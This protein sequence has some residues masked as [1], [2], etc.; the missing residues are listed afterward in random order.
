MNQG[1]RK[2]KVDFCQSLSS[3]FSQAF[4]LQRTVGNQ[5]VQKLFKYGSIQAKL[6][7]SQKGNK[8]EQDALGVADQVM[9]TVEPHLQRQIESEEKEE[10]L[11]T[12]LI[13]DQITPLVQRQ[14]EPEEEE[15][16]QTKMSDNDQIQRQ[17]AEPEEEEGETLQTK[18]VKGTS[19]QSSAKLDA[20]INTVKSGGRP[21]PVSTRKF[22]EARLGSDFSQ[23]RIHDD[24]RAAN[25][26]KSLNAKAFTLGKD[27]A[28]GA[29]QYMPETK[30]GKKIIAHELTHVVQQGKKNHIKSKIQPQKE[31]YWFQDKPPKEKGEEEIVTRA[32]RQRN[33]IMESPTEIFS[34]GVG[35]VYVRFAYSETEMQ[36]GTGNSG[37]KL[38]SEIG[39]AKKIIRDSIGE[40]MQDLYAYPTPETLKEH[41]ENL[42]T[43]ARLKETLKFTKNNPFNIYLTST[44]S[45]EELTSGEAYPTTAKIY[46]NIKDVGDKSKLQPAIR[47]PVKAIV[48][49]MSAAE[50][51]VEKGPTE[52]KKE[53]KR[54]MLHENIHVM[55]LKRKFDAETIWNKLKSNLKL[56]G[57]Q[58][59]ISKIE[60]LAKFYILAQEEI[61]AY[62][63]VGKL[64]PPVQAQKNLY[65][66]FKVAAELFFK[67]DLNAKI[68]V[69][70]YKLKVSERIKLTKKSRLEK[71]TWEMLVRFPKIGTKI[72]KDIAK[73]VDSIM[74]LWPL[75]FKH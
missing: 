34:K 62:A 56:T 18:Q 58:D 38:K 41:R 64:Y 5:A 49:G 61:F 65:E 69:Q 35:T 4:S 71:V 68:H 42:S 23:V 66:M 1:F 39:D 48:K 21:L 28:F 30:E 29:G 43:R 17:E 53:L 16:I 63:E 67:N 2:R 33:V 14:N 44:P 57:P 31:T 55:L 47:V 9:N 12:K 6:K 36:L 52:Q 7:N 54:I 74:E 37:E 22:F 24:V 20:Q 59:I 51:S 13:A 25:T 72:T 70:K 32:E 10:S 50:G 27:V 40:I 19:P 60:N 46:V 8:Y 11:Q 15:E 75:R 3:T 45:H 26:A 73:N